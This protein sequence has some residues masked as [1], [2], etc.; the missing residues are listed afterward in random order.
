MSHFTMLLTTYEDILV[1][2]RQLS[3]R[4]EDLSLNLSRSL[5]KQ[6]NN[7]LQPLESP[8]WLRILQIVLGSFLNPFIW[9]LKK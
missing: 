4:R 9:Y 3:K 6:E 1:L 8:P 2:W 7:T 5:R